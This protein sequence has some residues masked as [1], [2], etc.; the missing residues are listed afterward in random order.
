MCVRGNVYKPKVYSNYILP[1]SLSLFRFFSLFVDQSIFDK[2]LLHQD[3]ACRN[4]FPG[5]KVREGEEGGYKKGAGAAQS[6][7]VNWKILQ[8]YWLRGS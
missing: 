7:E 2:V 5:G 4:N 6:R 8:Y 1:A 3:V